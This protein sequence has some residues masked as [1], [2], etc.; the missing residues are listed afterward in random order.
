MDPIVITE[1]RWLVPTVCHQCFIDIEHS[2][3]SEE[4]RWI[5]VSL[6]STHVGWWSGRLRTRLRDA[7][8]TLRGD[9][10]YFIELLDG[11]EADALIAGMQQARDAAFGP[12]PQPPTNAG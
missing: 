4:H 3:R 5:S 2:E 1:H 6:L 9:G 12:T 10:R 8:R 11:E 7:W